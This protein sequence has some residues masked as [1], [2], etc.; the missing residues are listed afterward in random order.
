M[1]AKLQERSSLKQKA[2]R[3]LS[4]LDP[5]VIQHSPQLG[6]KRFSFLLEELN[7]ASIINDVLALNVKKE[8]LHLCNLKKSQLQEIF[9]PWDQFSDE[10][11][12]DTIY[13]S[14]L[15]GDANYKH[16]WEVIKICLVLSH[17]NAT[18][19]GGFS[20][21]KSLLVENM[22]EKT[23]TAQRHIHD[24]IQEA[25]RIKNIHFSKKI[26]DYVRGAQKCYHEYLAMKKQERSEEDKKKAE[27]R[28]LDIQE[29][30]CPVPFCLNIKHKLK[31]QQLQQRLQ[32]AQLLR[33]RMA[34]M[35]TRA[36]V[37][38][39]TQGSS[40]LLAS[41]ATS[42]GI[43]AAPT[44][45][46]MVMSLPSPHQG[47][48]L[49]PG[50]PQTPSP[51]VLQVVKQVQ[52][53]AARQQAPHAGAYGKTQPGGIVAQAQVMPPPPIQRPMGPMGSGAGPHLLPMDQ[54][55]TTRYPSNP[56]M[57]Q[58]P[59]LRQPSPQ[60]LQQQPPQ[61]VVQMAQQQGMG[62]MRP[63]PGGGLGPQGNMQKHA[64][65]QLLQTLKSPNTPEQQQQI[66]QIL[67]SNPQLM[68]AFIKQ[69]QPQYV[70]QPG[71]KPTPPP[72][73]SPQGVMMGPPGG[74]SVQQQQQMM[75]A[76]RSPP[77]IRSPQ[78]NPSPRPVPSPR[79]Q[80]VPSPR[81]PVPSP[82]HHPSP[83]HQT[84]LPTNE[85]MLVHPNPTASGQGPS[86][87]GDIPVLTPQDKLS[88]FVDQL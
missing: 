3:G 10:V 43:M 52:E 29:T 26:L 35:N 37:P 74:I 77:P 36:A 34:V 14:F 79:N 67:K 38:S 72:V 68:A 60:L 21:N 7:H 27:K 53:E 84:E 18:V 41:G 9:P 71:L 59:G 44:N 54:W 64:L 15:V 28:K 63:Q 51:N 50:T 73:P 82:H 70:Q 85:M 13:G 23:A 40:A 24:E 83:H 45:P 75:Q 57:Q 87:P 1:I 81:G 12:L 42:P 61:Q 17:G 25:G 88:K 20:V 11:G 2:V 32:Q 6:Q 31:Q 80:P 19:E 48:G 39:V 58:N 56:V 33:R 22:H 65:Q 62:P 76:V 16:L 30:K 55:N 78:P 8:Y 69:R 46:G 49:K 86:D 47:G 66:L 5:C 4:S